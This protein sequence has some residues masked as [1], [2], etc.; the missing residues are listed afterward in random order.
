MSEDRV[1]VSFEGPVADV[2]LNRPDK[3]NGLDLQMFRELIAAGERIAADSRV[4]AVVLSGEGKA[5]CAGLDWMAFLASG[6]DASSELL[7]RNGAT[8]AAQRC[9]WIWSEVPV[10]VIAAVHGAALGGGLQLALACDLRIVAPDAQLAVME[11]RYG[12]IP[13]MTAS[14]TLL[15]LVRPDLARELMYTGRTVSGEEAVQI[16]LATRL[17][18]DPRT[19]AMAMA[20][21]IAGRSPEAIRA[22]K[23]LALEAVHLDLAGAFELETALQVG[24]MGS[25]NQLEAVSATMGKRDP[26]FRDP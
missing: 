19:D 15:R 23:R 1:L 26:A 22:A 4:R 20:Q 6:A 21:A 17:S 16:G 5:F 9:C 18:D 2:R 3:R 14:Q 25:P 8:N 7:A 10:P 24:L 12:L 11:V 13:D